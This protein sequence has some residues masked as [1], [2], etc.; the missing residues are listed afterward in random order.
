[1]KQLTGGTPQEKEILRWIP[2]ALVGL[3]VTVGLRMGLKAVVPVWFVIHLRDISITVAVSIRIGIW[4]G[5]TSGNSVSE[6]A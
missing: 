6:R 4:H 1:M 5:I 3:I 2:D